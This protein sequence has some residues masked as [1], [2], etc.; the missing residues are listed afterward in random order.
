MSEYLAHFGVIGMKW[1]V[2]RYQNPDGTLT[3]AGKR[4]YSDDG[5]ETYGQSK[6]EAKY[7][8]GMYLKESG[9]TR[10]GEVIRGAIVSRIISSVYKGLDKIAQD[11]INKSVTNGNSGKI[12]A[13]VAA[14]L[15]IGRLA[16][17]GINWGYRVRNISDMSYVNRSDRQYRNERV[18][19][20]V[21]D[22]VDKVRNVEHGFNDSNYLAHY[23]IIGMKWGVRRTPEQLGHRSASSEERR[24]RIIRSSGSRNTETLRRARGEDINKLTNQQLQ[25]YNTRLNLERN[26]AQLT[27][28]RVKSGKDWVMKTLISGIVVSVSTQLVKD[29]VKK[30]ME[31]KFG[32]EKKK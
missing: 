17:N 5:G 21:L 24:N 23:G 25:D 14:A 19:N 27:E 2:R 8:R 20:K 16:A 15:K 31:N 28:G 26:Y 30:W 4:R 12:G 29:A 18:K 32:I 13:A 6:A 11:T 9:R 3:E 7:D 1:G 22:T 10:T